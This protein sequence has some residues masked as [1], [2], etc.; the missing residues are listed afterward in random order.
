MMPNIALIPAR[1]GSKSIKLKNIQI[2]GGKPLLYW[3]VKAANECCY[4]DKVVVA[5][6][7]KKIAQ[8]VEG[9]KFGKTEVFNRDPKNAAD[10]SSTE[11]V[12]LEVAQSVDFDILALIQATNPFINTSYLNSGFLQMCNFDSVISLVRQKRFLW[13]EKSGVV[14]PRYDL[15]SRPRRQEF[16][17]F[18]VENGSF[19]MTRKKSLLETQCR[20]SGKIGYV[21]MPEYSYYE[22]DEPLDLIIVDNI[23]KNQPRKD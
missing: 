6:D 15:N 3:A 12:A 2:V 13:D 10:E 5:T 1:G 11:S 18:L 8:I 19:Y 4:V 17:G 7:C 22:I 23:L 16:E 21:E 9:F 20:L 14:C